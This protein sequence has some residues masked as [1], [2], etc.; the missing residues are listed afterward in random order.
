[1]PLPVLRN[2]TRPGRCPGGR[3]I[4]FDRHYAAQLGGK[5]VDLIREGHNNS[6]A[7]LQ[8]SEARGVYLDALHANQLRDQWGIIHPRMVHHSFYDEERFQPSQR[9]ID[10]LLPIFTHAIGMEDLEAVRHNAFNPANLIQR[11]QSVNV[12]I[13][14]RIEELG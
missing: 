13:H 14:K 11:Y 5:A 7:T 2:P 3:P 6:V 4:R 1:M 9:G 10:F 12:D 8:S